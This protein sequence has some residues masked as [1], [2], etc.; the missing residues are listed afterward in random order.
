ME[1]NIYKAAVLGSGVMGASIA[2]HLANVGI[3]VY[4]LDIVPRELTE[5]ERKK[6][7]TLADP[8][9][10]NRIAQS[11]KDRLL[12]EKPAPLYDKA[13]LD[14]ITVGNMEDHLSYLGEA[15]WIIEAVVEN[16]DVKKKVFELV[17]AHRRPGTIVSSNT[18]GVSINEICA[19]RSDEFRKHFLGTHF[20]NPP[21]YLKLLE[22]IP[23]NDTDPAIVDYM[24]HFGEF[25]LGKGTVLCKDTPNF[26]ANRIGTFGLQVS[27]QEMMRLGLGIDEVDALTGPVIG[28]PKS[29]TFRTLDVVGLDTYVHVAN[30]VKNKTADDAEKAI[31]EVPSLVLQLVEKGWLGQKAGQGFF[32]QVKTENGK[33]ILVLD[34]NTLEYRPRVK[35]KFPSLEAAKTAKT[36]PEKLKALVYGKD[37]GSEFLW[38]VFKKVLLYSAA[39]AYEIADD[40]VAVDRA[41]KWGFGWELGPFETWD[42]IGVEKSVA[43]MREEGETIPALVEE[44]LASGKT[45]FYQKQDGRVA[46]FAV[47]GRY[48]DV[49]EKKE[50]INLAALKEQGRL[51]RKNAGAALVDLGDGVACLEFTSPH[52]AL[53]MDVLQMAAFAVEEVQRNFLGLVIGNQGKNFC[54]G[55]NLALALMEAQDENWFELD[56]LVRQFHKVGNAL[57]TM[58][59]PVVAAPFGMTLGGGVEVCFLADRVQAAAET[60]MGLVEVG[61]GLL[62]G[63]GGTK[64]MLFR[65][66]EQVPEGGTVPV[67]P[68]PFVARAFETIAMAKVSTSGKEAINLG[69]LRPSDR[70][71][72][73][74]DH[75]LY[76][77][78]QLVLTMVKEGYTPQRP[79]K[80]RV[81]GESGYATLRQSIY[82]MKKSGYISDHDELIASK[83]AYV[84]SGGSVP[85]GTEVTESYILELERQAFLELIKTPKTQQRMQ[86][87]LMK[88]KPLRN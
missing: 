35:A 24:M 21:R 31:F 1:R 8:V 5:D 76:D 23:G 47:G 50:Q 44:L 74:Q 53:G 37:K 71:S 55:M 63:G 2:A 30:N 28:R 39:K 32:K 36:L 20:F 80:I 9:V 38:S 33:E 29:A 87:M 13:N 14:L 49:E 25:V 58:H 18:S 75:L 54:V 10:R 62:P 40:I 57:R 67:D 17:E 26:I 68:F 27:I 81:I 88:N 70:I 86:H 84:M 46:V 6:G 60:Y 64:E 42:A 85:A 72:I 83:I 78:K 51:I 19:G 48:K 65:A 41:M 79:R 61:V 12:K 45:S 82:S 15:D 22:I 7:L 73:N 4:L 34:Y 69:Y 43:R 59:R 3:P 11:G 52:N 66:M 77:A 16:L 56:M